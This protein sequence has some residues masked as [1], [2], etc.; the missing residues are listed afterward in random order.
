LSIVECYKILLPDLEWNFLQRRA[1]QL[2]EKAAENLR[3]E[4]EKKEQAQS[5]GGM[6]M[7]AGRAA[8]EAI[9]AVEH[10]MEH[11]QDY[12]SSERKTKLARAAM[13]RQQQQQHASDSCENEEEQKVWKLV[14][15]SEPDRDELEQC[16]QQSPPENANADDISRLISKLMEECQIHNWRE[17]A[18]VSDAIHLAT[19][20]QLQENEEDNTAR[21][22]AWIDYAQ[23][24]SLG[25]IIV[26]ICDSSVD[27]VERLTEKART[28]TPKDLAHW[29]AIPEA[30]HELL[31]GVGTTTADLSVARIT[32][33][34]DRAH[35]LLQEFEWLNWYA[36]PI[37]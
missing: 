23:D 34:C 5:G 28:G 3:Q 25:E 7:D 32:T 24:E 31:V 1:Q 18:N 21:V 35:E 27:H 29:R 10:A 26:E 8:S 30:L 15:P 2:S 11:L 14:T 9:A 33:W 13:A 4:H 19:R 16:I 36:T 37:E 20:L 17:L 12:E 22:Q 6:A